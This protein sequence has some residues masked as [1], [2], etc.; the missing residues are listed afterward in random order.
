MTEII[1]TAKDSLDFAKLYSFADRI[2]SSV[3]SIFY[4]IYDGKTLNEF[5]IK[6]K[7]LDK[8][9][10]SFDAETEQIFSSAIGKLEEAIALR[11]EE[12]SE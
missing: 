10:Y 7:C 9:I 8:K 12:F 4:R 3:P 2:S 6:I 1:H 11:K 5:I